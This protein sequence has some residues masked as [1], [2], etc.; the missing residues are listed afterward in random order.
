MEKI[1]IVSS[2]KQ[3]QQALAELFNQSPRPTILMAASGAAAR[4]LLLETDCD[5]VLINT[6]LQ[7]EFG[8]ELAVRAARGGC[9]TL[10]LVRAEQENE[11]GAQVEDYGVFVLPRPLSR[12]AF[13]Q[14]VKLLQVVRRRE[15]RLLEENRRLREKIEELRIVERAKC[16]LIE[17]LSFSEEQAHRY[18]EKQA[19]DR[20]MTRR[21]VAEGILN[22]Y[23]V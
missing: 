18:I 5:L 21:S 12:A 9:G 4:R 15:E 8:G 10:L 3:S 2:T 16:V 17:H 19:R 11:I 13:Y 20:R 6:P 23:E 22:T 7:D 14:S 1:L